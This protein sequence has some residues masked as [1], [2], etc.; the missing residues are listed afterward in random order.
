MNTK[1]NYF[2]IN[3]FIYLKYY[4]QFYLVLILL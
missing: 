4:F 1:K 2:G 3:F